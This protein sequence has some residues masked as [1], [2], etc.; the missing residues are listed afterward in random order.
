MIDS[1]CHLDFTVFDDD[2]ASLLNRCAQLGVQRILIPGTQPKSWPALM[3]LADD[4]PQLD[5]AIGIHPWMIADAPAER[6]ESLEAMQ[7]ALSQ[8]HEAVVAVGETGLDFS[9]AQAT[10][11]QQQMLLAHMTLA[12]AH[13]L[14]LILHHRKSHNALIQMLTQQ[15]WQWGGVIHAFSGS[16]HEATTYLD[17]GFKLGLG[18]T[19]TY[20]RAHK[21]R[22]VVK[23]LPLDGWLLETDAPDMPVCG[24]QGQ[25]NSPEYL[26]EIA[27]VVA[28]LQ[29]CELEKITQASEQNYY[30]LFG[31]IR[32]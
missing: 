1:H 9:I 13:K 24:R 14:P 11:I 22:E 15:K 25:R 8:S 17:L 19:V 10:D 3:A 21:T 20:P 31:K 32:S 18:G 29:G 23:R 5:I 12:A 16:W 26:P 7:L 28:E 27:A 4:Y 6:D 30:Q 2:R